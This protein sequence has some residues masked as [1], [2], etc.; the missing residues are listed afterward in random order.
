MSYTVKLSHVVILI[1][2][3]GWVFGAVPG[4]AAFLVAAAAWFFLD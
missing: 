2:L 1:C 3:L 4:D